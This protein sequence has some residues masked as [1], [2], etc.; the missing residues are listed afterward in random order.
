MEKVKT[1]VLQ[2][3]NTARVFRVPNPRQI[4]LSVCTSLFV[5]CD[6]CDAHHELT[7]LKPR[8]SDY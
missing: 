2:C 1:T 5:Y 7:D 4:P 3:P 8:R 6:K